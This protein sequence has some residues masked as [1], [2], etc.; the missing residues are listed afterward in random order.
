MTEILQF[1]KKKRSVDLTLCRNGHHRWQVV[2]ADPFAVHRG[3]LIT[4]YRCARC[5]KER[6]KAH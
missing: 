6:V 1:P 2:N 3:E 4:R 5:G